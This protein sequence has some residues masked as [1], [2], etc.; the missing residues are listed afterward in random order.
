MI[1][2]DALLMCRLPSSPPSSL[3]SFSLSLPPFRCEK[4]QHVGYFT[5]VCVCCDRHNMHQTGHESHCLR[6]A[7]EDAQ[8]PGIPSFSIPPSI[9]FHPSTSGIN[10]PHWHTHTPYISPKYTNVY[11]LCHHECQDAGD[12]FN[13]VVVN[14]LDHIR[15]PRLDTNQSASF[16]RMRLLQ[17]WKDSCALGRNVRLLLQQWLLL[18]THT[19]THT[20]ATNTHDILQFIDYRLQFEDDV[21][22]CNCKKKKKN[23]D[24]FVVFLSVKLPVWRCI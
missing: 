8:D 20:E 9:P 14:G 24:K 12:L 1:W 15:L 7:L 2:S 16:A 5:C 22:P 13:F 6:S 19:H 3:P 4:Q 11:S 21:I 17:V 23:P 10:A 18:N